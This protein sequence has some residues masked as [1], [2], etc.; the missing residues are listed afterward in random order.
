MTKTSDRI[1]LDS[2]LAR[3]AFTL[4]LLLHE[5]LSQFAAAKPTV[6]DISLCA[7]GHVLFHAVSGSGTAP[8]NDHWVA[9][10]R[11]T[12]RRFGCSTWAMSC[13]FAGDAGGEPAFA[14]KYG[15]SPD[16]AAGYAIHGGGVPVY[17]RGVEGAVAV[18]VV[19]GLKQNED[20]G[21][22]MEAFENAWKEA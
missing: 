7:S 16:Q 10:K 15:L 21:V 18:V 13:K 14:A 19:S 17:V 8:D 12:V 11:A 4:G 1:V 6:I 9:R 5:R 22:I 2:F 3:D 20:H